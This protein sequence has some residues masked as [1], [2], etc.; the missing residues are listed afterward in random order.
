MAGTFL[1]KHR[2]R[3][4]LLPSETTQLLGFMYYL[5]SLNIIKLLVYSFVNNPDKT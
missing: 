5:H 3:G 4:H 2:L 1:E